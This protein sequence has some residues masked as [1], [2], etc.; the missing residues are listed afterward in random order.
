MLCL[1]KKKIVQQVNYTAMNIEK[2]KSSAAEIFDASYTKLF[3]VGRDISIRHFPRMH[4][5]R[6]TCILA[7]IA[8]IHPTSI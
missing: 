8:V 3:C 4:T 7:E 6:S 5:C 1:L 2:A